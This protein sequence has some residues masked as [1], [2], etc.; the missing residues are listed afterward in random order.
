MLGV[1]SGVFDFIENGGVYAISVENVGSVLGCVDFK[2]H[3]S[4]ALAIGTTRVFAFVIATDADEALC[5]L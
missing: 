2:A 4:K 5:R 1:T 3:F